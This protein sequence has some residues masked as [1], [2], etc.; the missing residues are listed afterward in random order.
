MTKSEII[1]N[2]PSRSIGAFIPMDQDCVVMRP[3]VASVRAGYN[4]EAVEDFQ[5]YE[6]T[7]DVKCA[8][9]CVWFSV[10]GG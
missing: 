7:Y 4:G 6:A 2:S 10:V 1:D 5:G 9:D 8:D 3:I